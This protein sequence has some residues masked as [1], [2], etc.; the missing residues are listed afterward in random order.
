MEVSA[1][2]KKVVSKSLSNGKTKT[3][4]VLDVTDNPQYPKEL[5]I[6]F[7]PKVEEAFNKSNPVA[8]MKV[9]ASVNVTSKEWNGSYYT[10]ATAWKVSVSGQVNK[11]SAMQPNSSFNNNLAPANDDLPF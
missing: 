1:T 11:P 2:I 7:M 3:I 6:E 4:C 10:T 5:A 8:G 9:D